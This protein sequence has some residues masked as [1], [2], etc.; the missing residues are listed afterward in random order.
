MTGIFLQ[1]R[2][3]STRLN[4]KA[5]LPLID[6]NVIE[7][8]MRN[9]KK[10]PVDVYALVTEKES[11]KELEPF[12]DKEG[13]ELFTGPEDDVLLRY[14]LAARHFN[15]TTMMRATGDNPLVSPKLARNILI[16]HKKDDADLS[17]FIN[18]PL[19][20]GVE[21]IKTGALENAAIKTDD[22]FEREHLTT[23]FYRHPE[24]FTIIEAPCPE[25]CRLP[26]VHVSLDT[27]DDYNFIMALYQD[28]YTGDPIEADKVVDWLKKNRVRFKK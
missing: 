8:A 10:V 6:G 22:P 7:H 23:Y 20:L 2:L 1:A 15:V 18:M 27:I 19:G 24:S 4:R 13:F 26:E 21:V 12:A 3:Q 28:I 25:N 16:L 11:A 14:L 5:L 9:L 17:H